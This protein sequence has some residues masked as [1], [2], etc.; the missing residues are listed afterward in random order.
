MDAAEFVVIS[1]VRT[2]AVVV[3]MIYYFVL[4]YCYQRERECMTWY[5]HNAAVHM[6]MLWF[7]PRVYYFYI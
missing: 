2:L 6:M 4:K 1:H 5:Y 7:I 3:K